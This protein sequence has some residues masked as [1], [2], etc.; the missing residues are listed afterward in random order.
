MVTTNIQSFSGNVE[1]AGTLSVTGNLISTTGVDKVDLSTDTT[2]ALRPVIF[3]TGTTGSQSLKTDP[4]ITY[5][6]STKTFTLT[7]NITASNATVSDYLIHKDNT[8][9]YL[10]FP[11]DD[12]IA[13]TTGGGEKVRITSTGNLGVG[14]A[15]PA[16][17]LHVV[18]NTYV[19]SNLTV[20]T[21]NLH[22]DTLTGNVGI[23]TTTPIFTL[24]VHGTSN[25]GALTATTVNATT[26]TGSMSQSLSNGSYLTGDAYDGSVARTFAVDATTDSTANKIVARDA[27]GNV[28]ADR[29]FTAD[30]LVHEGDINTY[31]GFPSNDTITFTTTGDERMRVDQYGNVAIGTTSAP[32]K[33]NVAGTAN[34][35][36]LSATTVTFSDDL[37][38]GTNKFFVDVS[39]SNVGIGTSEP[40]YTLDVTGPINLTS[41]IVMSG[42]VFIK[43][44]DATSNHVAIGP[45]AG[46]TSQGTNA[47]AVGYLA[48]QTNQHDNTVVLNASGSALNTVGTERT[49]I[50]PLRVATV[51]SNVMTYDQTTGEVMDSGG[52]ISNKF[53]VVS[54][55]P[56]S[57]LT[58]ATTTIQGHGKYV[59]TSSTTFSG[60][61]LPSTAFNKTTLQDTDGWASLGN[62]YINNTG[63]Q[64]GPSS[65]NSISGEW[66]RIDMPYATTLRHFTLTPRNDATLGITQFPKDFQLLGSNDNGTS[67][68]VL[69]SVTNRTPTSLSDVQTIIVNASMQYKSYAVVITKTNGDDIVAI[70]EWRLFTESFSVDGGIVTTTAAS[71][72]ETGFTEHPVAPM[73]DYKTYV[74]GHGTYEASA[75]SYD[76]NG[77]LYP[78][79]AFD[80]NTVSRWAIN[81]FGVNKYNATTGEWDQTAITAYPNIYTDDVGG[82]RYAGHWLQIKLPYAI[83]LSHSN[84][85]PTTDLTYRAPIDGVILGSNDGENWYKLTQFT[86]KTYTASMWTRIDVNATTPY[87]YFRMCTTKIGTGASQF[88]YLELTEWRLFSATG[89]TKMDNVLISGELAVDGGALQTSHIKWPKVPLKANESEGYV[90]SASSLLSS[91]F[92]PC[93]AFDGTYTDGG[94]WISSYPAYTENGYTEGSEKIT[95]VNGV[96]YDGEWIKIKLPQ[97]ITLHSYKIWKRNGGSNRE[98]SS[99]TILASNDD[100]NWYTLKTFTGLTYSQQ[101]EIIDIRATTAYNHYAL[102]I[103]TLNG[104]TLS[105]QIS[106]IELFESTLGV[107]TSATTAKLT[108][109]GGLGLAKGS[110][111]FAG[112]DVV[113][114]LPKVSRLMSF[115]KD[116][117]TSNTTP[118]GYF[119]VQP[120]DTIWDSSNNNDRN[121][122]ALFDKTFEDTNGE[123]GPHFVVAGSSDRNF[124]S[125]GIY[126][127]SNSLGGIDGDWVYIKLPHKVK[128]QLVNYHRRSATTRQVLDASVLGSTDGTNWVFIGSWRNA[129]FTP[130]VVNFPMNT[131]AYYDYFACVFERINGSEGYVNFHELEFLGYQEYDD[132]ATGV[133]VVH[134]SIPNTPGQQQLAV[135]YEAR[136]PNSY[137]FADS[138]NVYDLSGS[139]VTGT[140]TGGVGY[141]AVDNAFTFD[142]VNDYISGTLNNPSGGWVHTV[143]V[144]FKNNT[145]LNADFQYLHFIGSESTNKA[146]SIQFATSSSTSVYVSFYNNYLYNS[147][148]NL[149]LESI[150]QWRNITYSYEGGNTSTTN[151]KIYVDGKLTTGWTL[152]GGSAGTTPNLDANSSFRLATRVNN[153]QYFDGSIANFRVYGKALNAD[154]I[155]ELYEYD[156]ERFG[157]RQNLVALHKGNLGVGV[158][159]P[160]SRFE[161]AGADGLQEY[162]P[163]AMTGDDTYIEGHGV[164]RAS[165]STFASSSYQTHYAFD[166]NTSTA[167]LSEPGYDGTDGSYLGSV[168]TGNI[169]GSGTLTGEWIQIELPHKTFISRST[170]LPNTATRGPKTGSIIGSNDGSTWYTI[171]SFSGKTYT[172]N[173]ETELLN[174]TASTAYKYFRIVGTTIDSGARLE[175]KSWRLFGTPAPSALEDGHLTLGKALT[176]P[177]VSGHPAGAETPRAESLVVHYDTTVDS[178]VS[179]STVVDI[180]GE[181]NNGTLSGAVYSS[182]DRAFT[183]DGVDD[184]L[185]VELPSELEG[186]PTFTMSIWVNPITLATAQS[187]YDTFVHI[188][189]NSASAQVQLSYYGYD[190]HL[191]LGGYN[192]TMESNDADA[193]PVGQ[194]THLCAVVQSGAWSTT[195]KKLYINGEL[196]DLTLSGSGTTS[197]P[198]GDAASKLVLGAVIGGGGGYNHFANAKL[199]NFKIWGGVALTAE[200]V[201]QEYALGRTGKSLNLTDTSLCLGGMAPKA[202][203]DVRGSAL[204][205]GYVGIGTTNPSARLDIKQSALSYNN[206]I[207]LFHPS[208]IS[209]WDIFQNS[210]KDLNFSYNG[211]VKA[212]FDATGSNNVDQNFTGQHRTFIKDIPFSQAGDLE[213]LIVSSDQN[214]YIKMSGGI[215]A[216]S[217][218]ITTNESLPVVSLSTIVNDKKCFGVISAS[219]DP[220]TREEAYGNFVSVSNKE[221][222]DTRVYI[223]SVGEG[224][225]WVTDT[226]G[227]LESGD[228]IT[229]S[230]VAGYGQKQDSEFLA[231]YTVAKITMDCDFNPQDQPIQRIKQS[232]VIETHYTGM[233]AVFKSVPHEFVTTTVTADDEWSNVSISPSDVTYAEWSNL[234]A[235]VQNT[236]TLTYTQTSNVVYDVKYTKTTTANVTQSDPWDNVYVD[237]PNVSYEEWSNLEANVQNTYT[238]TYTKT[239][240]EE[241]T[242]VDDP[243]LWNIVYYQM[244]E[245]E[246]SADYPDAVKHETVTERL[247]NALDEH[248]QLQWEDHPTETEK[249]YK[250]RYL[251]ASGQQTDEANCVHKAAFVG[252]T[253][254]CG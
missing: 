105:T 217:N 241:R 46:Q 37:A 64:T 151:P 154:Q 69:S 81:G 159:H 254:H 32:Y 248:G 116:A 179:G 79:E 28:Y 226:N 85:H 106:E 38:V 112:S 238:L 198:A 180:S 148:S 232:N 132:E 44:H 155:R 249:A 173:V 71:G 115:P 98:P 78:W 60:R 3:S 152:A 121:A 87:Q 67:W 166:Y 74:E 89:V 185:T 209:Y 19:T 235:N 124:N 204:F 99:G 76:S 239:T 20:G 134:R 126:T 70:G 102:V 16:Y 130:K 108:V 139:G 202:Q 146:S 17:K 35:G 22:V 171:T 90:A 153:A 52:L 195:T 45:G 122:W 244:V 63:E 133:D 221:V 72:L 95:D 188:G 7:D 11:A 73:T 165:A 162:P 136:D 13:F 163:K 201:A 140:L 169:D 236:Y 156:A 117:L 29:L 231:N 75:S 145:A 218:A 62:K 194:W 174:A 86:G 227:P 141:D 252:V 158:A 183:F 144:W 142:G 5:N 9:T 27:S 149:K 15:A 206:G 120:N 187:N 172:L 192:Q 191:A 220:E 196:Y 246:V 61:Y 34:V 160:T 111:V 176:L 225:M 181:G 161:V 164:F 41:N 197:I 222:G 57:A 77:S 123:A 167:W 53:A 243:S 216:G 214:K 125:S 83:T 137:S 55:Q 21:A 36:A 47:V 210:N 100:V 2:N 68:S 205:T 135:Y 80:Y 150:D 14:S 96:D 103:H 93:Q 190:Y 177:R 234:E 168:V 94:S 247:E 97:K 48:G 23:G 193:V 147:Y 224:A 51:A 182:T 118:E 233:V 107:G 131:S 189:E 54:E 253:Y 43:A 129:N 101:D 200:E 113:M 49:Y 109:D 104:G 6:P 143:S 82:I 229:T 251:D 24:D 178:V 215:E 250:I 223:N 237:P 91:G 92:P 31:F 8:N 26:F 39:S 30:Y 66:I 186:D 65:I 184:Y 199:S 245:Q 207:R 33:L 228:Y 208:Q 58:G 42:E 84:V 119:V 230:N 59:V 25:V 219:E 240:T 88:G 211:I 175:G 1:V 127:G 40:A 157:Y 12:T 138:S 242:E 212:F 170:W 114:E 10:G 213:G 128:L 18:G 110:Q 203:L 50:K 56:P 4:G